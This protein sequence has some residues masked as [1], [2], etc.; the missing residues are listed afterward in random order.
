M[1]S[2]LCYLGSN[3]VFEDASALLNRLL[4]V[5]VDA[6]QVQRISE[7]YGARIEEQ[8]V[9]YDPEVLPKLPPPKEKEPAIVS[10][11]G[12]M[13]YT[14]EN[15]WSEM[16]LAR[17]YY[18]SQN[19]DIHENR[20]EI[21]RSIYVSHLGGCNE[22]F[23]KLERYLIPY[24]KKVFLG[25][26][27]K[28]IWRFPED[29]YP[30][31]I[32]ILDAY[33]AFEKLEFFA[34]LHIVDAELRKKWVATEKQRLLENGVMEVVENVEKYKSKTLEA[35]QAKQTLI[36]Y[37]TE[38]EERMQYRT[39]REKGLPIG[40]G[41]I[42]AAHRHVIQQRLKLSGQRWSTNGAQRIANLR[43]QYKSK[44]D[45]CIRYLIKQAC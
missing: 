43:C 32:Q 3:L 42:E 33:H 12:S 15:G 38:N 44:N 41:N 34:K 10:L 1:Q 29:N 20:S 39:Y 35:K 9:V 40:S 26:G 36:N 11:D 13:V 17:I 30:G 22:F 25:D 8:M 14:K 4:G 2:T 6:S 24:E 28:W 19:I 16:K 7:Y 18:E 37:Y 45:G 5:A 27:A 23:E 31:A 21:Q